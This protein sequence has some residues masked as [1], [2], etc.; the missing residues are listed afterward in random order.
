MGAIAKG[1]EKQRGQVCGSCVHFS[2]DPYGFGNCGCKDAKVER[3]RRW[4]CRT[5]RHFRRQ[6]PGTAE[7]DE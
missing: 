5:C 7:A 3:F 4:D 6:G 1:Y 2:P